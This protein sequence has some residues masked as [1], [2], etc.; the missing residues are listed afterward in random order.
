MS[1]FLKVLVNR[2]YFNTIKSESLVTGHLYDLNISQEVLG[3]A[4]ITFY[5]ITRENTKKKTI[6]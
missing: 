2:L 5:Q 6:K 3:I 4:P 1:E